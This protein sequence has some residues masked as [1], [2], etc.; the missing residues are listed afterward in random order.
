MHTKFY[1]QNM[2]GRDPLVKTG[3]K[4]KDNVKIDMK[5]TECGDVKTCH[6]EQAPVKP[7]M[8]LRVP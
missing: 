4:A 8:K 6:L 7:E 5:E 3:E 2:N 1:S